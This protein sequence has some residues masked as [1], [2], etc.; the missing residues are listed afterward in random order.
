MHRSKKVTVIIPTK[1]RPQDIVTCLE[2]VLAQ[3]VLP[4]EVVIID[5]SDE[6]TLKEKLNELQSKVQN[7]LSNPS[8]N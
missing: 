4:Q 1:N 3:S 6:C 7:S 8:E 5:A 2:S